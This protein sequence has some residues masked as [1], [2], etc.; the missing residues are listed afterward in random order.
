MRAVHTQ[1]GEVPT[2]ALLQLV[3]LLWQSRFTETTD[4]RDRLSGLLG[5]VK[6]E[7]GGEKLLEIGRAKPVAGVFLDL[8][9]FMLQRGVFTHTLWSITNPMD[10]LP[11]WASNWTVAS[12]PGGGALL[13][14]SILN[15]ISSM[16]TADYASVFLVESDTMQEAARREGSRFE[17]MVSKSQSYREQLR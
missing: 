11:S 4:P 9:I 2:P 10:G 8:S 16:L 17:G 13:I 3:D 7:L 15:S 1:E 5:I 14:I 12:S 6:G